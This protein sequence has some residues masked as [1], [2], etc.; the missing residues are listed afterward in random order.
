MELD[1]VEKKILQIVCPISFLLFLFF[2]R[3]G[4]FLFFIS[5]AIFFVVFFI[6]CSFWAGEKHPERKYIIGFL[7]SVAHL[8]IFLLGG[9]VG[10]LIAFLIHQIQPIYY[11]QKLWKFFLSF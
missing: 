4:P 6:I 8:F 11:F 10:Y 9:F 3:V 5:A 1:I 2:P 7:V